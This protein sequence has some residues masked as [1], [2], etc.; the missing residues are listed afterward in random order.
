[1]NWA[2]GPAGGATGALSDRL[3]ADT[4]IGVLL[5]EIVGD[6]EGTVKFLPPLGPVGG[7]NVAGPLGGDLARGGDLALGVD[8]AE[9]RSRYGIWVGGDLSRVIGGDRGLTACCT[10]ATR[11][12]WICG[13]ERREL[14]PDVL[15]DERPESRVGE[16]ERRRRLD[17]LGPIGVRSS[18]RPGLRE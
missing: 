13:E 12:G 8:L 5:A 15:A 11:L 7:L 16:N 9:S 18:R 4:D 1:M 2:R 14:L 10:A 17:E 3:W 6:G